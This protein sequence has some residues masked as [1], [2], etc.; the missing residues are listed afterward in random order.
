M[1]I[2]VRSKFEV[3]RAEHLVKSYNRR[4]V[5]DN[6]SIEI[7]KGEIVGLLGPNG[8]GKSTTFYMMIGRIM[9]ESGR[10][11][12]GKKTSRLFPCMREQGQGLATFPRKLQYS[13]SLR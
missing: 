6:V 7:K 9:P 5:V 13:G 8:A 10:V 11:F 4:R 3:L 2:A 1:A 12:N